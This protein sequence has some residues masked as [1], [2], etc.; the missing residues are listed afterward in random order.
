[1]YALCILLVYTTPCATHL[2]LAPLPQPAKLL[3]YLCS[4]RT[5]G[6]HL[7]ATWAPRPRTA[8]QAPAAAVAAAP[9]FVQGGAC[10]QQQPALSAAVCADACSTPYTAMH[11]PLQMTE[12]SVLEVLQ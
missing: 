12:G 3:Q 11:P 2:C 5:A 8:A 1:M 10:L 4:T 9:G 7:G 6:R